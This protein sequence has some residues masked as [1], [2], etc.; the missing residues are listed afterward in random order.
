MKVVN[1]IPGYWNCWEFDLWVSTQFEGGWRPWVV[2]TLLR[3]L[4]WKSIFLIRLFS[5][6]LFHPRKVTAGYPKW[7]AF[8]QVTPF[9][10]MAT[11]GIYCQISVVESFQFPKF[12]SSNWH[13]TVFFGKKETSSACK[14]CQRVVSSIFL[15][16]SVKTATHRSVLWWSLTWQCPAGWVG[17]N[18]EML[19]SPK[20]PPIFVPIQ[21]S[22]IL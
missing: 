20:I 21:V 7:W 15:P 22:G 3:S 10:I 8:E 6:W 4:R 13:F 9:E 12:R 5:G 17:A 18:L 2:W 16:F 19:R 11:F 14:Q 1:S